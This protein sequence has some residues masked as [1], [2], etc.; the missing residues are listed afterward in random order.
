[1]YNNAGNPAFYDE[2]EMTAKA[3]AFRIDTGSDF[4]PSQNFL[5]GLGSIDGNG[6]MKPVATV[7]VFRTHLSRCMQLANT[8][9]VGGSSK[10]GGRYYTCYPILHCS[11]QLICWHRHPGVGFQQASRRD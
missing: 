8:L 1:M 10:F 7:S 3:G 11:L 2:A 5:I 4:L 6:R 9:L